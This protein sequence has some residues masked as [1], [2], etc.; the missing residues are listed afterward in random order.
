MGVDFRGVVEVDEVDSSV[1]E[2]QPAAGEARQVVGTRVVLMSSNDQ[3]CQRMCLGM[4]HGQLPATTSVG[5]CRTNDSTPEGSGAQVGGACC[6]ARHAGVLDNWVG[7]PVGPTLEA[8][9]M[10]EGGKVDG[11]EVH[12]LA[13]A[14]ELHDSAL[15]VAVQQNQHPLEVVAGALTVP[16]G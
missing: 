5:S 9:W 16:Q 10:A 12:C 2:V 8:C 4:L 7:W 15:L 1:N 14:L 11:L 13:V 6:A 3:D